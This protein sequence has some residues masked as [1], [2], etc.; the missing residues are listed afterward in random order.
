MPAQTFKDDGEVM[1]RTKIY[2][3]SDNSLHSQPEMK[4]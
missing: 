2:K 4:G 1:I 3:W